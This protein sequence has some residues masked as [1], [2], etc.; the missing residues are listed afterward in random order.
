MDYAA[1]LD[2]LLGLTDYERLSTVGTHQ[3][4]YDLSRIS[5]LMERLGNAHLTVPTVHVAGTKGKGSVSALCASA[6]TAQGYTTGLYTSPHLHTF[7]ERIQVDRQPISEPDFAALVEAVWPAMEQV[8]AQD[9]LGLVTLFEVLT[10][11]SFQCF[12]EKRAGFQ[13]IEVGL[14]GRLDATNVV[15]PEVSVI[16]ALS[17]DHTAILGSTLD[18][19]AWE[20]AGIIKPGRV[21]VSAPQAPEA[22]A[23]LRR[24]CAERDSRLI[25]VGE[26]CAWQAGSH[27][28]D[29]QSLLVRGR[30][31]AYDLWMP[32]LGEHQL[33]NAATSVA[34]LE[35]LMERGFQIS[36]EALA[37]GFSRV[38][39]PCRMEVLKRRPLVVADGAHNADSAQRLRDSVPVY[40]PNK[41]VFLVVGVSADKNV[42]GIVNALVGLDPIVYA[43]RSRHPRASSPDRLAQAFA[44][45]GVEAMET[46]DVRTALVHALGLA[47]NGD[48]VLVTG[49]LFVAAEAREVIKGIAPEAYPE[50]SGSLIVQPGA[51]P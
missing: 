21:T 10:A 44:R 31:G 17:L 15:T 40:L 39:W 27:N 18:K 51:T 35:V 28:L 2:R 48:L 29:G 42:D 11:M 14:G 47:R 6:L 45:H 49:S 19:I 30:L 34:A 16:T 33:E 8:N 43:T 50:L 46:P 5:A 25:L 20:K 32:L 9:D 38:R 41:R 26:D 36:P 24:I 7:R 23:V 37:R 3:A 12:V 22:L 1:A 4:R 13:V